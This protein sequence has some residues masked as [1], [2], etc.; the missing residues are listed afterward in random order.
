MTLSIR[1]WLTSCRQLDHTRGCLPVRPQAKALCQKSKQNTKVLATVVVDS[2]HVW[3]DSLECATCGR[4]NVLIACDSPRAQ[5]SKAHGERESA[6]G[7]V[8][9]CPVLLPNNGP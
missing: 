9:S 5:G 8:H 2:L 6:P 4:T 3:Y 7:R 1:T